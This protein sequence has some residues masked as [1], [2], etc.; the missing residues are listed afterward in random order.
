MNASAVVFNNDYKVLQ[1]AVCSINDGND[2][3][4]RFEEITTIPL[5]G[6]YYFSVPGTLTLKCIGY[7]MVMLDKSMIQAVKIG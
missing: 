6:N 5:T 2:F 3:A 4:A 7:K 1:N